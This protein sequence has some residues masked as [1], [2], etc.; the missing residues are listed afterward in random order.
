MFDIFIILIFFYIIVNAWK[1][2]T[3]R[4]YQFKDFKMMQCKECGEPMSVEDSRNTQ[5]GGLCDF[6]RKTN[7][8]L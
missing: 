6:C 2:L 8:D 3:G 1:T 7:D 4:N 5:N